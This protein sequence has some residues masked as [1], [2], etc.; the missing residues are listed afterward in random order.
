MLALRARF[1][2]H[3]VF[4]SYQ[5][6]LT[7]II[8]DSPIRLA[9]EPENDWKLFLTLFPPTDILWIGSVFQSGESF[10]NHFRTC[11]EWLAENSAP[12]QFICPNPIRSDRFSRSTQNLS[13][14]RFL[15]VESD[16]L[17]KEMIGA[18]FQ[19]LRSFLSL[20]AIVDTA[21]KS[22]HGWFEYPDPKTFAELKTILPAFRCDPALFR[23]SQPVRLPGARRDGNIQKLLW[24]DLGNK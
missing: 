5:W 9:D 2:A 10:Q 19:W 8:D 17:P 7:E 12:G 6:P 13:A 1:V 11:S 16:E 3:Q 24:L 4:D 22:L 21:G 20:R 15:V 18:V 23:P 14:L